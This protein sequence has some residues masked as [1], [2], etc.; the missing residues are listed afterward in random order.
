MTQDTLIQGNV[1]DKL[2][3]C[4]VI[5]RFIDSVTPVSILPLS[6]WTIDPSS[7]SFIQPA[8]VPPDPEYFYVAE[9]TGTGVFNAKVYQ[10]AVGVDLDNFHPFTINFYCFQP[11][12]VTPITV[13]IRLRDGNVNGF[14][15]ELTVELNNFDYVD[16]I[17]SIATTTKVAVTDSNT[18]RLTVELAGESLPGDGSW[19]EIHPPFSSIIYP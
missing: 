3:G 18:N 19:A 11:G 8:V 2:I 5:D 17:F 7:L 4:E 6:L 9:Q 1:E 13:K 15:R 14:Y 10:Q 16:I 12:Q